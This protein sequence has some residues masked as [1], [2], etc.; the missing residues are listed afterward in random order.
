M[1]QVGF[2]GAIATNQNKHVDTFTSCHQKSNLFH[3]IQNIA[4]IYF[5]IMH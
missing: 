4:A 5:P 2:S 3:D 1:H